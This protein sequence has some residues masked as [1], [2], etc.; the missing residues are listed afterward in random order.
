MKLRRGSILK[1]VL[2][3]TGNILAVTE[4][5]AGL[6][7]LRTRVRWLCHNHSTCRSWLHNSHHLTIRLRDFHRLNVECFSLASRA[8]AVAGITSSVSFMTTTSTPCNTASVAPNRSGSI[9]PQ[10]WKSTEYRSTLTTG[11]AVVVPATIAGIASLCG[12]IDPR[13]YIEL[14]A[15]I[16]LITSPASAA[17][18]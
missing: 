12:M 10:T 18:C 9:P 8:T 3:A 7:R 13:V 16:A 5:F 6:M 4:Y 1:R 17:K 11:L 15:T 14:S 2:I